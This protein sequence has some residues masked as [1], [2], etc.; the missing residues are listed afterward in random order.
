LI[1]W[2]ESRRPD[3][4]AHCRS[5]SSGIETGAGTARR[6]APGADTGAGGAPRTGLAEVGEVGKG[7]EIGGIIRRV[8]QI[9]RVLR[10]L[11]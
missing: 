11:L 3:K 4:V 1:F 10:L 6:A 8:A 2:C 9:G 7:P 5:S